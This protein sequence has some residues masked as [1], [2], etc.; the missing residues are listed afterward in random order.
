MPHPER[1]S[2]AE[3]K[4]LARSAVTPGSASAAQAAVR[5]ALDTH[6]TTKDAWVGVGGGFLVTALVVAANLAV[7]ARLDAPRRAARQPALFDQ[8]LYAGLTFLAALL[9]GLAV[10]R[11]YHPIPFGRTRSEDRQFYSPGVRLS[12]GTW[13]AL[14]AFAMV[15]DVLVFALAR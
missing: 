8:P 3:K 5:A 15:L 13:A 9:L 2:Q 14:A 4:A 6:P 7:F 1:L 11:V 12:R 10:P